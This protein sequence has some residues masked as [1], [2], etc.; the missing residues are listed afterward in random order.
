MN[1]PTP[2]VYEFCRSAWEKYRHEEDLPAQ[3]L[4]KLVP[5]SVETGAASR[6]L[7]ALRVL[8]A[9]YKPAAQSLRRHE[10]QRSAAR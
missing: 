9:S 8:F 6:L 10:V 7:K 5:E 2:V 1:T 3:G 4:P